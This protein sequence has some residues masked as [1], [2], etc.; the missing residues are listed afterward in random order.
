[1]KGKSK[2]H[3]EVVAVCSYHG[4]FQQKK[5][6]NKNQS[7]SGAAVTGYYNAV[8][9]PQCRHWAKIISQEIVT[10]P[11]APGKGAQGSLL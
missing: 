9:C 2:S 7:E 10:V 5:K 3:V 8:V 6:L 11:V 1:M 4:R